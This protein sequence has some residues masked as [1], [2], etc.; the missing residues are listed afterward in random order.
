MGKTTPDLMKQIETGCP[1]AVDGK[2]GTV[3]F[4]FGPCVYVNFI[5]DKLKKSLLKEGNKIRKKEPESPGNIIPLI[6][7]IPQINIKKRLLFSVAG[8]IN[9]SDI[10]IIVPIINTIIFSELHFLI[11]LPTE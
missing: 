2:G 3:I 1:S 6:P 4:P 10:A 7:M 9:D 5:S 8:V 11:C